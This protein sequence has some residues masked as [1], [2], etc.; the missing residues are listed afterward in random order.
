MADEQ[1]IMQIPQNPQ[2][3]K[4]PQAKGSFSMKSV[5]DIMNAYKSQAKVQLYDDSSAMENNGLEGV[6]G[7][8]IPLSALRPWQ[9]IVDDSGNIVRIPQSG[10]VDMSECG[11]IAKA[12]NRMRGLEESGDMEDDIPYEGERAEGG[13]REVKRFKA[14]YVEEMPEDEEGLLGVLELAIRNAEANLG[15]LKSLYISL[16]GD[17]R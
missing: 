15:M 12:Y 16:G 5:N 17:L 14:D 1:S 6:T 9:T 2:S 13:L 4:V 11:N 7:K 3:L 10:R 8:D